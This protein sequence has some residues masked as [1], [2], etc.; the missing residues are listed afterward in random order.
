MRKIRTHLNQGCRLHVLPHLFLNRHRSKRDN[1]SHVGLPHRLWSHSREHGITANSGHLH[2][3]L[4]T[5]IRASGWSLTM[6][7]AP[8]SHDGWAWAEAKRGEACTVS[9]ANGMRM[10]S[11]ADNRNGEGRV[12][13]VILFQVHAGQREGQRKRWWGA[14]FAAS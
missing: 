4:L 10:R 13:S 14:E 12:Q 3:Q 1:Q 2:C 8:M 9:G 5:R 11:E 6:S 7:S